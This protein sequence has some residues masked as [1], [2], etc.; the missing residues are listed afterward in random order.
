[1][2]DFKKVRKN[3]KK[4][5]VESEVSSGDRLLLSV[6]PST[7]PFDFGELCRALRS[8]DRCP[9]KGDRDGWRE[10]FQTLDA[11]ANEKYVAI[12]KDD[13]G[14]IEAI[15]LTRKGADIA[16]AYNDETRGLLRYG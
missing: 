5:E 6:L 8:I 10:L 7:E 14:N 1:M 12:D 11:L 9:V 16:R 3:R 2:V 13:K 4:P 15:L